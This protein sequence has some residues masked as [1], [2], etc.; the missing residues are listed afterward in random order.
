MITI[1]ESAS[2]DRLL[3]WVIALASTTCDTEL[4]ETQRAPAIS[5]SRSSPQAIPACDF[6]PAPRWTLR[7][8]D[9]ERVQALVEPRCGN[10]TGAESFNRCETLDFASKNSF[11]CVR[12]ID[13]GGNFINLQYDLYTGTLEPCKGGEYSDLD[14]ELIFS[15]LNDKC[16]GTTYWLAGLG[17]TGSP[18][19]TTARSLV[20]GLSDIWY[21][22]EPDCALSVDTW[23][24]DPT[25]KECSG[26]V[27]AGKM[28][29]LRR[30]PNWVKN[31]LPNPP[32]TM[33][34]EYE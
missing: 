33:A 4:A 2:L 16:E 6:Q 13:H 24:I 20:F 32:Y 5:S 31:L 17:G 9:G 3:P 34:V 10:G 27:S 15:Y 22:A 18:E 19:F 28:C 26:P 30:V 12:I 14:S 11:P 21:F 1:R 7:D 25:T 23:Y 29:P 8:K